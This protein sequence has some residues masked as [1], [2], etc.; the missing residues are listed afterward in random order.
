MLLKILSFLLADF[1]LNCNTLM[2]T[3]SYQLKT[4]KAK[5]KDIISVN[6]AIAS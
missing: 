2:L 4:S 3:I 5:A 1:S 6:Y